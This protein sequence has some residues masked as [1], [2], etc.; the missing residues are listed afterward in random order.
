MN[1]TTRRV[2]LGMLTLAIVAPLFQKTLVL[3]QDNELVEIQWRVP[4]EQV[5]TIREEL[6]FNKDQIQPDLS[7]ADDTK[8]VPLIYIFLGTVIVGQLAKT[9]LDIYRDARYGGIIV[10]CQDGEI[11]IE[12]DPRLSSGTLIMVCQDDVQVFQDKSLTA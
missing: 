2:F 9:L 5:A 3:S 12:N 10:S 1:F 6:Q 11:V 8:G 7:S 4:K